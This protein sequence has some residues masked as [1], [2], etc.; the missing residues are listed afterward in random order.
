MKDR[1]P[2][3]RLAFTLIELLVVIAIIAVLIGLL[4]PAVQKVREA[5]NRMSCTNHL[6]Q[7]GLAVHSFHDTQNALP[8]CDL[9]DN[10][11]TWAVL[12][13]PHIEQGAVYRN[14][15][16]AARYYNQKPEAGADLRIY[17]C[18]SRSQPG[19]N[20]TVG[21]TRAVGS[22]TATGPYGW[23]DYAISGGATNGGGV[24]TFWDGAGFRAYYTNR[25]AYLNSAQTDM[26]EIWPGWR[27]ML[28]FA[29]IVDGLSNTLLIGEKFYPQT[30]TGGVIYNGDLQSQY[31]RW[32]GHEGTQDPVTKKW[33]TERALITDANYGASDWTARFT[34]VNH[35]GI[36]MFVSLDGSVQALSASVDLEVLHRLAKRDDGLPIP[37]Y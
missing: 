27:Y 18:P 32:A 6:K 31:L 28:N 22:V 26:Y 5:A 33:T 4:L 23:G 24:A 1:A 20:G 16:I 34:A 12:I 10:W 19:T 36:G 14:W 21:E 29:S 15:N 37:S 25:D 13:M 2:R 8:A 30:S 3:Q 17:H 35:A 9:G 11:P 7:M